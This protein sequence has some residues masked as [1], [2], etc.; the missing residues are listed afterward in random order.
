MPIRMM[1]IVALVFALVFSGFLSHLSADINAT[2][3]TISGGR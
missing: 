2:M 3:T 1:L